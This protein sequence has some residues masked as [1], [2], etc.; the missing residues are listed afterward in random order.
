MALQLTINDVIT[1]AIH[2]EIESQNL[3]SDLSQK[4]I[5]PS[6]KDAFMT[7]FHEE[8]RHQRILEQYLRGEIKDGTEAGDRVVDYKLAEHLD[9]PEPTPGMELKHKQKIEFLYTE[10]AFPQTDGG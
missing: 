10:V 9:Q 2:K 3:Y 4:M 5:D 8:Q 1:K 7:L 6:A